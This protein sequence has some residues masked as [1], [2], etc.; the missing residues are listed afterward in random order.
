[1]EQIGNLLDGALSTTHSQT[2]RETLQP[3]S[4]KETLKRLA[5]D[6]PAAA[7]YAKAL[8][9]L[10]ADHGKLDPDIY[11]LGLIKLFSEYD[12]RAVRKVCD[13]VHGI[14]AS[15]TWM[16]SIAEVKRALDLATPKVAHAPAAIEKHISDDERARVKD[17]LD[18]LLAALRGEQSWP[19]RGDRNA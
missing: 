10:Y 6:R 8:M 18:K 14:A 2:S 5:R 3:V 15:Q 1:M 17:G 16:P 9:G 4:P 12:G 13:P 7:S 11:A 19:E